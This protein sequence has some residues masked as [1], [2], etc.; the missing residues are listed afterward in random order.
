LAVLVHRREYD[1]EMRV[2]ANR[3]RSLKAAFRKFKAKGGAP[4]EDPPPTD[5]GAESELGNLEDPPI[6]APSALA[7]VWEG[8]PH[9]NELCSIAAIFCCCFSFNSIGARS[10]RRTSPMRP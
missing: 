3:T 2:T 10:S 7:D 4:C 5:F 8:G 6:A 1:D 9:P